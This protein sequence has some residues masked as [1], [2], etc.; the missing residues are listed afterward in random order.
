MYNT[1]VTSGISAD[2]HHAIDIECDI[3]PIRNKY[4][5]KEIKLCRKIDQQDIKDWMYSVN[6]SFMASHTVDIPIDSMWNDLMTEV[7]HALEEFVPHKIANWSSRDA[8]GWTTKRNSDFVRPWFGTLPIP[9][10][11]PLPPPG[12]H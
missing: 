3:T 7:E 6:D 10:T 2:G 5:P 9:P 4:V 12:R 8:P 11:P 1:T